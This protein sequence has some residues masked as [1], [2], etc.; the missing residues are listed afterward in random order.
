MTQVTVSRELLPCP[1]C[2][3]PAG[4]ATKKATWLPS[5]YRV[6]CTNSGCG[7]HYGYWHPDEWNNRAQPQQAEPSAGVEALAQPQAATA[8]ESAVVR[9]LN[10]TREQWKAID[11][12]MCA[13][14]NSMGANF[15]LIRDAQRDIELLHVALSKAGEG[16]P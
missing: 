5:R 11:P 1:F 2:K 9:G 16:K 15:Y 3:S 7:A 6:A 14:K 4:Q 13:M 12:Q 8:E 10:R